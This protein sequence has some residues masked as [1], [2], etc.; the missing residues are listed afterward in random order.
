LAGRVQSHVFPR[1]QF[2]ELVTE[3][4]DCSQQRFDVLSLRLRFTDALRARITLVPQ[5]LSRDLEGLATLFER[6]VTV[7]IEHVAASGQIGRNI[8]SILSE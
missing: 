3:L 8:C 6:Q 2:R 4:C 7:S 1:V 5:L